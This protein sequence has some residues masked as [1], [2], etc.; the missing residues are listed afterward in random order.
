MS[1]DAQLLR[2]YQPY[3]R[4]DSQEAYFADAASTMTDSP[5]D[6][7]KRHDG[8]VLATAG[9]GLSLALLGT[10]PYGGRPDAAAQPTDVLSIADRH[11]RERAAA[12]HAKA[13]YRNVV[14]GHVA[15]DSQGARWLQYWCF[16]FFNDYNLIGH[17]FH[18]GLHEGDWEMVQLRLGADDRPDHAVYAQHDH[19]QGRPWDQVDVVPGTQ[20]P[21]VYVARGSHA[22]YFEPGAKWTGHW[23]DYADGRRQSPERQR[24]EVVDD[25][26]AFA[27]MRWPGRWGDTPKGGGIAPADSPPSP[28][29]REVWR[30]PLT[31]LAIAKA[32][33]AAPLPPRPVPPPA[34]DVS[35]AWDDGAAALTY[36]AGA[37]AGADAPTTL[38]IT[39]NS[40][41]EQGVPPATTNVTID[42]R[43]G[44]VDLPG[45]DPHKRYDIYVSS[46]TPGGLASESVRV[47]LVPR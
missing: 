28:G 5:G 43:S 47:D 18:A 6:T 2:E 29:R 35:A 22:A 41:D 20:R 14:Y 12:L 36:L 19:A 34:P 11:Y 8:T 10:D 42:A 32:K 3:L 16:Y 38:T 46:A 23:F 37:A 7:L 44:T 39:V 15:T 40:K 30:D 21:V 31:L 24:L 17:L 9:A 4:F 1:T 27:W 26:A 33:A 25:S 13:E 45:L